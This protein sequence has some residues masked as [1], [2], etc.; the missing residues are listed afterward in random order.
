ME[1]LRARQE[2][3]RIQPERRQRPPKR[4]ECDQHSKGKNLVIISFVDGKRV[5]LPIEKLFVQIMHP[6]HG[7]VSMEMLEV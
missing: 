2:S 7:A 3:G 4:P 6:F 5:S 1:S